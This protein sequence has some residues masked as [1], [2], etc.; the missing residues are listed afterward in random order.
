MVCVRTP[1]ENK[2]VDQPAVEAHP[3]SYTRLR[4][5]GLFGGHQI[6]EIAV[7]MRHRQ[8]RQNTSDGLVFCLLPRGRH[9]RSC[10]RRHRR[11]AEEESRRDENQ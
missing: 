3:Y 11:A 2:R 9:L 8:H 6:V 4:V 10:S 7:E 1:F 5:V